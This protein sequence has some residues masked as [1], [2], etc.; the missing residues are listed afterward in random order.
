MRFLDAVRRAEEV[1]A[2]RERI[3]REEA[4]DLREQM[5]RPVRILKVSPA[6]YDEMCGKL[7]EHGYGGQM[8]GAPEGVLDLCG[9]A[10][11]RDESEEE[12][13]SCAGPS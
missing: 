3:G 1:R 8:Y 9:V 5:S 12:S 11:Q 7:L 13:R 4:R 2:L 6:T 10:I